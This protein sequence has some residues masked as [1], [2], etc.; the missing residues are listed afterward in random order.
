[1]NE[2]LLDIRVR[3]AR[4]QA[5]IDAQRN[6]V[7]VITARWERPLA[8]ADAGL[9]ALRFVKTHPVLIAA[10]AGLVFYRRGTSGLLLAGWRLW[11]LYR[12]AVSLASK[13]RS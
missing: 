12:S 2:R 3:R 11:G 8:V 9:A 6:A 10:G 13:F 4:L 5:K 1:M 7:G